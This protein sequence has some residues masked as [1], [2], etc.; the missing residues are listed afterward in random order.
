MWE[1]P[2]SVNSYYLW[3]WW[4]SVINLSKLVLLLGAVVI[5]SHLPS[6]WRH[7]TRGSTPS[8]SSSHQSHRWQ[9]NL[10]WSQDILM[11]DQWMLSIVFLLSRLWQMTFSLESIEWHIHTLN[12]IMGSS[13]TLSVSLLLNI[14][15]SFSH[16]YS[17]ISMHCLGQCSF[18]VQV[19]EFEHSL[20]SVLGILQQCSTVC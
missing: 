15:H 6:L 11:N 8:S 10:N 14:W 5:T 1:I 17:N 7:E 13:R 4:D 18:T 9:G 19:D 2:Q 12:W 20:C 16:E 3:W